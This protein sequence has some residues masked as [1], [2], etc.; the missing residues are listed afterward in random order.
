M[1]VATYHQRSQI[2]S[3]GTSIT[4]TIASNYTP[5]E[6]TTG[7]VTS[8]LLTVVM[9]RRQSPPINTTDDDVGHFSS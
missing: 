4:I 5:L 6:K 3:A 9:P 2:E 1:N 7:N 8:F